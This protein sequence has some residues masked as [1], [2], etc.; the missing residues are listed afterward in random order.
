MEIK[1]AIDGD[2]LSPE[3]RKLIQESLGIKAAE[4]DSALEKLAKAAFVEYVKMFKEKGLP[5]RADEVQQERLYFLLVHYFG[6]RLPSE[7]QISSIFQLTPSQAR[8]FCAT[9][10]PGTELKSPNNST[11]HYLRRLSPRRRL[12]ARTSLSVHPP[13]PSKS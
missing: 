12:M 11:T 9:R 10:N 8:T 6:N 5:T 13:P 7:S 4:I 1:I 2:C 3:D